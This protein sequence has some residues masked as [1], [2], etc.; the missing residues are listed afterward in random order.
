MKKDMIKAFENNEFTIYIQPKYD[1][2]TEK[3]VGGEALVRWSRGKDEMLQ[4]TLFIAE[5]EKMGLIEKL[6]FYVFEEVCKFLSSWKKGGLREIP[7]SVNLS[8]ITLKEIYNIT[9]LKEILNKYE[10]P[11][12]LIEVELTETLICTNVEVINKLKEEGFKVLMDDFGTGYSSL[13]NLKNLPIDVVKIDREFLVDVEECEEG[14]A[15]LKMIIDLIDII[16]K[17]VIVE[18]I[19]TNQQLEF[20]KSIGCKYAQGF[21]F[22]KPMSLEDFKQLIS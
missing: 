18:G 13:A 6:D 16:K 2:Y 4:P 8:Q 22:N 5:M 15:I 1:I 20:I 7:I 10:L 19:E 17:E 14:K 11:V 3:V 9:R 12:E 21:L